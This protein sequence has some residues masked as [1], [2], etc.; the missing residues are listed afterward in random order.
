MGSTRQNYW[1]DNIL[2]ARGN[3]EFFHP[4]V[5]AVNKFRKEMA[6]QKEDIRVSDKGNVLVVNRGKKGAAVVNI[7]DHSSFVDL[8]TGLPNGTYKD[9]VYGHEFKVKGGRLKGL[10]APFRSYILAK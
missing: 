6:G 5:V 4:E 7:A 10:V 2:G 3:D 9:R 1:G 8:P